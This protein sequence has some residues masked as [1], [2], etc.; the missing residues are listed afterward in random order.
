MRYWGCAS[1]AERKGAGKCNWS[2]KVT[3]TA[4]QYEFE[5][6]S[7]DRKDHGHLP[8]R[9][10]RGAT[11]SPFAAR[12]TA[13]V[14]GLVAARGAATTREDIRDALRQSMVRSG[15][16]ENILWCILTRRDE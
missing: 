13:L 1:C 9:E 14:L 5:L 2:L 10:M 15:M 11:D 12:E 7:A 16:T 3:V 8:L 4:I 6:L